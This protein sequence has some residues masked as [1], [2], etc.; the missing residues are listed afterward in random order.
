MMQRRGVIAALTVIG[1][2][3]ASTSLAQIAVIDD[4]NLAKRAEDKAQNEDSK[5]KKSDETGA[6]K[7]VVCTYSN[8]YR[9]EMFGRTPEQALKRDAA[10]VAIIRHYAKKYGVPE[11]L[12]LA[13]A[14]QE[15]RLDTCAGS[16]TGVKGVMQ[17]TKQTGRSLGFDRD[18]NEQNIEGGIAYLG[19]G[20]SRCGATN[21]S[22]LASWYNGSTAAEQKGWAA[23]VGRWHNY[24]NN[25]VGSPNAVA[26]A[27]PAFSISTTSGVA[28]SAQSGA[29]ASVNTASKGLATGAVST[30]AHASTIDALASAVGGTSE[31]KD[32]WEDNSNARSV[33]AQVL[34]D[35]IKAALLLNELLQTRMQLDNTER[36]Q[37]SK[38]VTVKDKDTGNP[39]SCDPAIFLRAEIAIDQWPKCALVAWIAA[40]GD[41]TNPSLNK[42][43]AAAAATV[44]SLQVQ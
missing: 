31:Y 20:V 15:S 5:E 17:L 8:K 29:V 35:Y 42:D 37:G 1:S 4:P 38:M 41:G 3:A 12:A 33:N 18:I 24:F 26:A 39:F 14:Y 13:V 2:L 21:Y 23:G 16:H 44:N 25:Y 6:K 28:G 34:N 36:S 10:N 43:A 9:S 32:A 7:A 11:G 19:K 30:T 40:G 22:C 27:E